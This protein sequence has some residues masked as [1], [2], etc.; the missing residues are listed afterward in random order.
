MEQV[1]SPY[2]PPK[3]NV[4]V[5]EIA[6]DVIPAGRWRRFANFLIDY[7]GFTFLGAIVGVLVVVVFGDEGSAFLQST[8]DMLVG[9]PIFLGY[10]IVLEGLTGRT[11]GKLV[12]GTKVVNEDG[13]KPTFGQIVGRAFS[14]LIP[15]EAFS[16]FGEQGRGWHDRLP[17][18]YVIK[19]R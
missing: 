17:R 19:C 3:S 12:T 1:Q 14:R 6:Q 8:P 7:A 13:L 5:D 18:T 11:L 4:E 2:T 15:F 16:F 9:A 10:Y